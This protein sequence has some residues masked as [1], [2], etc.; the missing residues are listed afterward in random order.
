MAPVDPPSSASARRRDRRGRGP[1]GPLAWPPVPA[2]RSRRETFDDVV[3]EVAERAREYLGTR[4]AGV[5]FAVEEVPSSDPAPWEE[6]AAAVGRLVPVGGAVGHR[7]VI[8]RRPVETRAR[9]AAEVAVIVR[10]VVAEQVAALLNVPPS[11]IDL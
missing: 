3:I 7:I 10:E 6:Q 8:Y 5:E 2:M 9:D 4:Y 1:R 11:E